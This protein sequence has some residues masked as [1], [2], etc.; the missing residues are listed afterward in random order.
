[1]LNPN[2]LNFE[3][4]GRTAEPKKGNTRILPAALTCNQRY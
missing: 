1:V 3:T 2:N 4:F